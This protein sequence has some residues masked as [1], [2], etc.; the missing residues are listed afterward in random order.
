MRGVFR[1]RI[2]TDTMGSAPARGNACAGLVEGFG[3]GSVD[4]DI[5]YDIFDSYADSTQTHY[6]DSHG[7]GSTG[8]RSMV[9]DGIRDPRQTANVKS[10]P[11]SGCWT[12]PH[13]I[14]YYNVLILVHAVIYQLPKCLE[15]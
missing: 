12:S 15:A 6:A 4:S 5:E 13:T 7:P 10:T 8:G 1:E 14:L 3:T 9:S 11:P 2:D